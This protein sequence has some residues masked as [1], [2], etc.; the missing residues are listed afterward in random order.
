MKKLLIAGFIA[1]IVV[2]LLY[3]RT[4][5]IAP[6]IQGGF[7]DTDIRNCENAIKEYYL[8]QLRN[9]TSAVE[10]QEVADGSTTIEVRMI[11]VASRRLEGYA[12]VSINTKA[13]R[14]LGLSEIMQT[15]EATMEMDSS[16][17][18]WKCKSER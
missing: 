6:I 1:A 16:Q 10:R 15:C 17:Y 12:K 2:L 3:T 8:G 14:D 7:T 4:N 18:I 11:K 5:L 9:S 13:A